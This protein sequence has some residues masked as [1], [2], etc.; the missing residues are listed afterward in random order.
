M[1][2][3]NKQNTDKESV[4]YLVFGTCENG[5]LDEECFIVIKKP[6]SLNEIV[7]MVHNEWGNYELN[8]LRILPI[9]MSQM[10][11]IKQTIELV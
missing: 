1:P 8:K 6:M 11:S 10:K 2:N 5:D 9:K 3:S 7:N 4:S